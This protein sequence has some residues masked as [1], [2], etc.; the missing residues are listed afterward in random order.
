LDMSDIRP[1]PLPS[2]FFPIRYLLIMTTFDFVYFEL[3][4]SSLD[5][6]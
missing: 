4:M 1:R 6:A 5:R 3:L 2:T